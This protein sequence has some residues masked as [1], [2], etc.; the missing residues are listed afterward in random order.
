MGVSVGGLLLPLGVGVWST[1]Q[2]WVLPLACDVTAA[3]A[4]AGWDSC[5]SV[6]CGAFYQPDVCTARFFSLELHVQCLLESFVFMF[7]RGGD[8]LS[9]L[10]VP[11]PYVAESWGCARLKLGPG[12]LRWVSQCVAGTQQPGA[13]PSCF[14]ESRLAGSWELAQSWDSSPDT[15]LRGGG[16]V[17]TAFCSLSEWQLWKLVLVK[18]TPV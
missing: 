6:L 4:L 1:P 10:L 8:E 5:L 15:A 7:E 14:A 17:P 16:Q 18:E 9:D 3:P 11:C 12:K 13:V 2:Q